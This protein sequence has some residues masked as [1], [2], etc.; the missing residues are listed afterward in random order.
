MDSLF[1]PERLV[2]TF[3]P[4]AGVPTEDKKY[5]EHILI[6]PYLY[7]STSAEWQCLLYICANISVYTQL[8]FHFRNVDIFTN[9]LI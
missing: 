8:Y 5:E 1:N 6:E 7:N 9:K 2:N 3:P 4:G